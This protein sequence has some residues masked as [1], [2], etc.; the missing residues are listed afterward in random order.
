MHMPLALTGAELAFDPTIHEYRHPITGVVIPSV[1]QIL[2]AVGVSTDFDGLA[3]M[4]PTLGEAIDRKRDLGTAVHVGAHYYDDDSLE[5]STVHDEVKPYLEAWIRFRENQQFFPIQRE[6]R[7]YSPNLNV[8]G[9]L[10]A[11]GHCDKD[12]GRLIL[13]DIKCGDP[14]A[15]AARYQTAGYELLWNAE[16]S[17]MPL[18]ERWS[19]QL[20]PEARIPYRVT[21]YSAKPDA[22]RDGQTFCAFVTTYFEQAV[23][24]H[25]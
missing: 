6:R 22:W 18:A 9:T 20:T 21:N 8:C 16:H 5:W 1:T 13:V 15:S 4:S 12:R 23:R 24:R 11:V 25:R 2:R 7:L 10:D 19:V 3:A 17:G 14:E